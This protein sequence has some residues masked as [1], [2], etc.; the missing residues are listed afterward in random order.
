[1]KITQSFKS[2]EHQELFGYRF[3][4]QSKG[5]SLNIPPDLLLLSH[6]HIF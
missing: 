3:S 5:Y 6:T 4:L 2:N 1:M